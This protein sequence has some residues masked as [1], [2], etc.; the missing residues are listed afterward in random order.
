MTYQVFSQWP[1]GFQGEVTIR[2]TASTAVNGW[3]LRW[4][5]ADG[6]QVTQLWNGSYVQ[7]GAQVAVTNAA[8]NATIQPNQSVN[9]GFLGSWNNA[10][11]SV[12][13]SFTLNNV[14]CSA[15]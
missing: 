15:G 9:F 11:N 10:V 4:S 5:F 7:T 14:A 12:P 1:G 13:T 3:T 8:W 6:Q 2:N